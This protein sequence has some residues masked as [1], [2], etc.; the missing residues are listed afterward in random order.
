MAKSRKNKVQSNRPNPIAK[1]VKP[2]ADPEL[3]A[4]RESKILPVI[5]DLK[6]TD[7]KSRTAAAT[8]IATIVTDTKCRKLL[9]REQIVHIVL[10]ETLTDSS[11]DG[12]A[13]GWEIL[14]VLSQEEEA[15]FCVHLY[16]LDI[17]T[18]LEHAAKA[19]STPRPRTAT[20][21]SRQDD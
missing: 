17:L 21:N 2:P 7:V 4:L 8:A 14:R 19:V 12:R 5:N 20:A 6:S 3:A 15:D 11:I 1:P 18:A 9:L 10:T 13:A 16:R